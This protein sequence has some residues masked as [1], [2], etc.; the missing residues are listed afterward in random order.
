MQNSKG[1]IND[2]AF[3]IVDSDTALNSGELIPKGEVEGTI[4]FEEPINDPE[5]TLIYQPNFWD[6]EVTKV[7]IK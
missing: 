4:V 7:M 5:L 1:Q 6:E 2:I 3:T